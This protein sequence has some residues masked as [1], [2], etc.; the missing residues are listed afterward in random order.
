[1]I[2]LKY[3]AFEVQNPEKLKRA[4]KKNALKLHPSGKNGNKK[5]FENMVNEYEKLYENLIRLTYYSI[6]RQAIEIEKDRE[7]RRKINKAIFELITL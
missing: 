7:T 4:Y 3:F 1:M 6:N 2:K 5:E